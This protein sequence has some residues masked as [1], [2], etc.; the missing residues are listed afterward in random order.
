MRCET[1]L[2]D[3]P[4]STALAAHIDQRCPVDWAKS[5][6]ASAVSASC[7]RTTMCRDGLMQLQA[8]L[9]DITGGK[10]KSDD[11][12]LLEDLCSVIS[13]DK[14]C[15][16]TQ[17][18]AESVLFS[19]REYADEW[20]KH[21]NRKRCTAMVCKAYY[22]IYIDPA[23]CNGCGQCRQYAPADTIAGGDGLIHVVKNDALLKEPGFLG[24]CPQGAIRK[25]GAIKPPL[26]EAP[27]PV[28]TAVAGI[29]L[30]RRRGNDQS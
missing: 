23:R 28:G 18:A 1:P 6:V 13:A 10:G 20:G 25:A 26:P 8:L 2:P 30:R 7:G 21:C 3:F 12:S 24:C 14:D 27:I 29:G 22:D 15:A 19:L 4:D 5:C 16:L 17:K 9:Q 11:L